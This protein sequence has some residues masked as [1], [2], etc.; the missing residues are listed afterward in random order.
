MSHIQ[1]SSQKNRKPT[2]APKHLYGYNLQI[3]RCVCRLLESDFGT[4]VSLE[5]LDDVGV[6]YE[7]GTIIYEQDKSSLSENN[8]VADRSRDLWKTISN[9]VNEIV[10]S[11]IDLDRT[12]FELYTNC[13]KGGNI[14]EKFSNATKVCEVREAIRY[15]KV[16]LFDSETVSF[17]KVSSSIKEYVEN[18]FKANNDVVE[19]L[20]QN[21]TLIRGEGEPLEEIEK[22]IS[23]M[24]VNP[25]IVRHA[26]DNA[27]G[28]VTNR[29]ME[30]ITQN[31][32]AEI[33]YDEFHKDLTAYIEKIKQVPLSRNTD[34][35]EKLAI[36]YDL[37]N[38]KYV[39]QLELID[40]DQKNKEDS[41][42]DYLRSSTARTMWSAEGLIHS[43]GIADF[44]E[45]LLRYW[46]GQKNE[47][48][49]MPYEQND[50]NK[51]K[52]LWGRCCKSHREKLQGLDV[53]SYFVSGSYHT[54]SDEEEIGWH[55]DYKE[56][57][58][59]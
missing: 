9:W 14:V 23:R 35:P 10:S 4:K 50:I 39:R 6:R 38:A 29:F 28:W 11:N 54:L 1:E 51:G 17:E 12:R 19:K 26:T 43:S 31:G 45:A 13:K 58:K 15:A 53:P 22:H 21:F 24:F 33:S 40:T 48:E 42:Y 44:E 18:V 46:D 20:I 36:E 27:I 16:E 52:L 55:P 49:F 7:D 30:L 37:M 5:L 8:P 57:L 59:K 34:E 56:L 47:I 41:V 25:N 2:N 32:P 3:Q